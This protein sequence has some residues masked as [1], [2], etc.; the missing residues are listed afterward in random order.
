MLNRISCVTKNHSETK[1]RILI[2]SFPMIINPK[3]T[4]FTFRKKKEKQTKQIEK[5]KI[6]KRR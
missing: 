5:E 6:D 4:L 3:N 1:Q 2:N